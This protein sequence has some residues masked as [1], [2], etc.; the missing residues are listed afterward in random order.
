MILSAQT[1]RTLKSSRQQ[2]LLLKTTR[3]LSQ[4]STNILM[5]LVYTI[6]SKG[7]LC[8]QNIIVVA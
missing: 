7:L 6:L 4:G 5:T 1:T 8:G 3:L 2:D